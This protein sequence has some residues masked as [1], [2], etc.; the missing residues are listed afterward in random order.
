[1]GLLSQLIAINNGKRE[2]HEQREAAEQVIA[3]EGT[4]NQVV[5]VQGSRQGASPWGKALQE[6]LPVPGVR[7]A[8]VDCP[9]GHRRAHLDRHRGLRASGYPALRAQGDRVSDPRPH[10]GRYS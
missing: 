5:R 1:M 8:W 7:A 2:T 3:P 10:P 9:A 6:R 4:E